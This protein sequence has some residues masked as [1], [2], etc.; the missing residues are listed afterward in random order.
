M[1]AAVI[2]KLGQRPVYKDFQ[3]PIASGN[4]VVIDVSTASLNNLAK[5]RA[6][7]QHYSSPKTYPN[8]AGMDGVGL[9]DSQRVYF[10]TTVAP[11]GAFA[12]QTL[13]DKSQII[14]VPDEV[15]DIMAAAIANPGMSSWTAL[16]KRIHLK[17]GQTV[18]INGATGSAGSL[19]VKIAYSL[20][21]KKVIVTGRNAEKLSKLGADAFVAFDVTT[22]QG[23]EKFIKDL[24]P[25]LIDKVD[26]VIDYLW[27]D[28]ALAII[29]AIAVAPG[30]Y[31]TRFANLGQ[32]ANQPDI[33]LPSAFLRASGI[34]LLGS[35]IKSVTDKDY[36]EGI[37]YV[38]DLTAKG[39]LT[40]PFETYKL[41]DI[42]LA[43]DKP[44]TPRPIL[45][46]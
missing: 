23:T 9:L 14:P 31:P 12:E 38:F 15:D 46:I 45:L 32:S 8:V 28:S 37:S 6:T 18:L 11:F 36:L 40:T 16:V 42:D 1:K 21:A 4:S 34:E 5:L 10:F 7:G 19:A 41:E 26:A 2:D 3:N 20:G 24:Q 22:P 27:G 44:I 39:E 43:W 33:D 13:V 35:G 29:N 30:N 25:Y 17:K